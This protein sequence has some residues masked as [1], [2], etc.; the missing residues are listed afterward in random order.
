M[1]TLSSSQLLMALFDEALEKGFIKG[2][3][4]NSLSIQ[5]K[6][7]TKNLS[8][9][10]TE[11]VN[12]LLNDVIKLEEQQPANERNCIFFQTALVKDSMRIRL[13]YTM[14]DIEG[15]LTIKRATTNSNK[16]NLFVTFNANNMDSIYVGKILPN[17][18]FLR[19]SS[20]NFVE[21]FNKIMEYL[22]SVTDKDCLITEAK[23]YALKTNNCC[24]CK[25]ELTDE[26]SVKVG[27][28]P[29]CAEYF[30]LPWE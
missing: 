5:A 17:G 12:K 3:F 16:G 27:Y 19:A 20:F 4:A 2:D 7:D 30:G 18:F 1:N 22:A 21:D 13:S 26:I 15:S 25:R 28:G 6:G 11:W 23:K 8:A 9:K 29:I 14:A 24:F 10:Q